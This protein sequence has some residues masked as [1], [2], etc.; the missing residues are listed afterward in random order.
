[1]RNIKLL[2]QYDGTRYNGWQSQEHTEQTIQ[3]KLT[4]VLE[5]MLGE[6]IDLQGSGRTDAGV[7]AAGQTA[8]FRTRS[9]VSCEEILDYVNRYLPEDIAVS[10]VTEAD[11]RF[12]SRLHACRKTYVYRIWNSAIPNVFER[13]YMYQ[14][15]EPLYVEQ[16]R[17]AA[18]LLEGTHDFRAFCANGRTKKSTVRTLEQIK[19]ERRERELSLHFTGN[20]FLYHMVRILTGTLLEVGMGKRDPEEMTHILASLDRKEAG[21]MAPAQGLCLW[22]VVYKD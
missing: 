20:G 16:M 21:P 5:R 6:E 3:G 4:K 14:V 19:I 8:N 12:H 2:I 1:M 17:Q 22:N 10:E 18:D 7:H 13:K 9:E 15:K 11:L